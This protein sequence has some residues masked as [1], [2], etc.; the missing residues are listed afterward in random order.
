M[1]SH[2]QLYAQSQ[3]SKCCV[4]TKCSHS[5]KEKNVFF[6]E[7]GRGRGTKKEQVLPITFSQSDWFIASNKRF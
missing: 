7:S 1:Y 5:V 3:W 4:L 2:L 6:L